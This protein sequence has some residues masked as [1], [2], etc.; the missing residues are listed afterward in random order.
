[1]S[2]FL[3][4]LLN[5]A[6]VTRSVGISVETRVQLLH[7]VHNLA[8]HAIVLMMREGALRRGQ[9]VALHIHRLELLLELENVARRTSPARTARVLCCVDILSVIQASV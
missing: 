8:I 1:M 3:S 5:Y 9:I 2:V 4:Q 7:Y 6:L